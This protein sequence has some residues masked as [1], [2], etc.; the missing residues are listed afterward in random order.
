[1]VTGK[2]DVVVDAIMPVKSTYSKDV[3]ELVINTQSR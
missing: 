2:L 3:T 1:M